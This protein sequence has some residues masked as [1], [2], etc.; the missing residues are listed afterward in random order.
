MLLK[1]KQQYLDVDKD[2]KELKKEV[3]KLEEKKE[4][5]GD[6]DPLNCD[7]ML[8]YENESPGDG[9]SAFYYDNEDFIGDPKVIQNDNQVDFGWDNEEPISGIN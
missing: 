9:I 1:L 4:A 8:G 2:V 3:D 5:I 7:G 6:K